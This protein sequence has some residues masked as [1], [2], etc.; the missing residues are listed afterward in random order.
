[1]KKTLF[2]LFLLT[3]SSTCLHAQGGSTYTMFG[4]GDLRNTLGSSYDGLGGT[5]I[6]VPSDY[7][8]NFVNPAAWGIV[9][10]TRFQGGFRFNQQSVSNG[11]STIGQNNGKLE[12]I[13][14]IFS[15]D[16]SLGIAASFGFYPYSSVN[17][18]LT[19]PTSIVA[20]GNTIGGE[21][22]AS[23]LGGVTAG[24]IG[25]GFK[26]VDNLSF[27]IAAVGLFGKTG[28]IIETIVYSS[29]AFISIN[30]RNDNFKGSGF[31]AGLLYTP[32]EDLKFGVAMSSYAALHGT[33]ELRY[34]TISSTEKSSD[35]IIT[36]EFSTPMPTSIGIGASYKSGKF[37][38]ALDGEMQD[39][40]SFNYRPGKANFRS[41]QRLSFGISRLAS[42]A[43]GTA[44]GDR[45]AFNIG[46][47]FNQLYY[48]LNGT[49]I[50]EY[51]G[52]FG[53]QIPVG[54]TAMLDCAAT[55]GTR[56]ATGNGLVQELFGR[57]SVTI[58]IGETWFK[59][60]IRE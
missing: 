59:P 33:S 7:A 40:S 21:I 15:I 18:S 37:L 13:A 29:E 31:K 52:S 56:G 60:F 41:A 3:A 16:T 30:Q 10:T 36:Q 8:I 44:F 55:V 57:F 24:Y 28:S 50:N 6:A 23:G 4:I 17:Y 27:G 11:S 51:F 54:G 2:L 22:D 14:A 34:S 35:T 20:N 25:G 19:T 12:G 9:K 53:M 39:F 42:F 47:G 48:T 45:I 38:F 32:I 1:M 49:G 46:G 5:Q 43:P 58:G 26:I